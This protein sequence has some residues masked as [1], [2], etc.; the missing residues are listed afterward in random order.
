MATAEF[1]SSQASS[2]P[3]RRQY[4]Y[5]TLPQPQRLAWTATLGVVFI[6][7]TWFAWT[8]DAPTDVL[9]APYSWARFIRPFERNREFRPPGTSPNFSSV[10]FVDPWHGWAVGAGVPIKTTDG[11]ETWQSVSSPAGGLNAISFVDAL[12]GWAVGLSGTI[13][14]TT[15]GGETWRTQPAPT[16]EELRS[17][18]FTSARRGWAVGF[19]DSILTTEDGGATWVDTTPKGYTGIG[20]QSVYFV[21]ANRGW[22]VGSQ[23]TLMVT[24][25]GGATWKSTASSGT[26][27]S[28]YFAP[29]G[30][31]GWAAGGRILATTTGGLPSIDQTPSGPQPRSLHSIYFVGS[32]LGWTV[33]EGASI[34]HTTDGGAH[35]QPQTSPLSED[36]D[37][38]HFVNDK[39]GWIVGS[40]GTI[41]ATD[42]G[43][44]HWHK[45]PLPVYWKLCPPWY[46]WV[47]PLFLVGLAALNRRRVMVGQGILGIPI[48]D[49]P[50]E[51]LE[52]DS[53]GAHRLVDTLVGFVTNRATLPPL[54]ITVEGPWGTGKSS[55][56]QMIRSQLKKKRA[57]RTV[58]FNAWH[59]Q[60][61]DP[62]LAYLLEAI[63]REAVPPLLSPN[64]NGLLFRLDLLG[65][66]LKNQPVQFAIAGA[67]ILAA[68]LFWAGVPINSLKHV[69][70]WLQLPSNFHGPLATFAAAGYFYQTFL[71]AFGSEPEKLLASSRSLLNFGDLRG[72]TDVRSDFQREL[73]DVVGAL[74]AQQRRLVIF[75]DDLDRCRPEQVVV[76]M[77]AVN[78]LHSAADCFVFLG[79]DREK[80]LTAVGLY[81][82]D[83]AKE[84]ALTSGKAEALVRRGLAESYLRKI[85]SLRT[86]VPQ[87][88][89]QEATRYLGAQGRSARV[90]WV[91]PVLRAAVVIL[92][93]AAS[94]GLV[95]QKSGGWERFGATVSAKTDLPVPK[96]P[97][98][99][100]DRA[101]PEK[102]KTPEPPDPPKLDPGQGGPTV[103]VVPLPEDAP[104][105]WPWIVAVSMAALASL[106]FWVRVRLRPDI[107]DTQDR[108]EFTEALAK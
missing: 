38:V 49:S 39:Q 20:L 77:E 51:T 53:L 101:A 7:V 70:D 36:L 61:E 19:D 16:K 6:L 15:D 23:G 52:Q 24:T 75:L 97:I 42:D 86:H 14:A 96:P 105:Q 78:F 108:P 9:P 103:S 76:I 55:V 62:L 34:L 87:P 26:L 4:T 40:G 12:H 66:R 28:V 32:L 27:Y 100:S 47:L 43:G 63:K 71:R 11:G 74:E 33:G 90:S 56:L 104:A 92:A 35:W 80:V 84:E 102:G 99:I 83:I 5:L 45:Q 54:C 17:V 57:A 107:E 59:H 91:Q 106:L 44:A 13:L 79:T 67:A 94:A 3:A 88:E 98:G 10:S 93:L 31:A 72:K 69:L 65:I 37:S 82:K 85:I 1:T 50:A 21:D 8:R 81:Y 64:L 60:K 68:A 41:L 95:F 18:R 73:R 48:P 30:Q 22:I 89:E 58:W 25:D 46:L 29:D 2:D